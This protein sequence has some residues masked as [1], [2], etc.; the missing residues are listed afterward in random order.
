LAFVLATFAGA[1]L[2]DPPGRVARVSYL[3]G[4]VSFQPAGDD[5]WAQMSLNRPLSTGDRVFADRDSRVELEIGAADVRLDQ[6]STFDILNLDDQTAQLELT[7]GVMNLHVRR[8]A[9]GQTYEVDTPTLAFVVS[10]PGDYRIDIDPQGRSTMVTVFRGSGD[11]YGENSASYS[12]RSGSSYR[13]N[14]SALR[15]YEVLDLPR[16]DDFDRW[17]SSRNE[18]YERAVSRQYVSEDVIGYADLDDYGSWSTVTEYG[19]VWYPSRVDVGWAPYRYGHWS[20]IDPWGWSWIDSAPWGFAPFHYGRWVYVGNRWGWCPGPRHVVSVYAP[21]MVAFVGGRNW[22]VSL[23]VGGGGPVGWFPLGPRDVYVPWYRA[24]RD[25][26]TNVNVRNTTVIN[27]TYITN[28]YNNYSN[29]RPITNVNYAYRANAEAFTAVPRDAF[30]GARPVNAARVQINPNNLRSAEVV[31][32]VGIAPTRASFVPTDAVRGR[33]APPAAAAALNRSVIA[34]TAPPPRPAPIADRLQA[35]QRNGA[36]PLAPNQLREI[37]SRSAP[38]AQPGRA[39]APSRIQVVGQNARAPQP[40]PARGPAAGANQ[41]GNAAVAPRPAPNAPNAPNANAP[42]TRG[43]VNAPGAANAPNR[44]ALPSSRF[45]PQN[46]GNPAAAPQPG[47]APAPQQG[48]APTPASPGANPAQRNPQAPVQS[49]GNLPSERFAPRGNAPTAPTTRSTPSAERPAPAASSR[50]T[51]SSQFAPRNAPARVE[52][53]RAAPQPARG[54]SRND[55]SRNVP[56][57]RATPQPQY[58]PRSAPQYQAPRAEPRNTPQPRS[59]PQPQYQPRSAP[60]QY[61]APRPEPRAMP[62]PRSEPRSMPQQPRSAPQP[63]YQPR[64]APQ[65]RAQPQERRAPPPRGQDRDRDKDHR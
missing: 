48:R 32:R 49:R 38:A 25:Y 5:Q 16:P 64:P 55:E 10:E 24:S 21:A 29:G 13:F 51:P 3:R 34:R 62:Q 23:N 53:P 58:Q 17:V 7:D 41:R 42:N 27:N 39:G 43:P 47:R 14:D 20:W 6:G 37:A 15:D 35:I 45:A 52:Q 4:N 56:Q 63:Q 1:A 2:A 8:M 11:V 50:S 33:A 65:P 57:P 19:S 44:A 26:F 28:V 46:R 18:R 30:V 40:L 59:A 31:S 22:G 54:P 9:R 12:V 36:Q 60:Q 61:Q